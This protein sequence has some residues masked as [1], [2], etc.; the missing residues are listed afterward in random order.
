MK[1]I[2]SLFLTSLALC[3][4]A[5]ADEIK[6]RFLVGDEPNN[7]LVH[8]DQNNPANN[9][10]L[11]G[12]D[13][14][15]W[16]VRLI[17]NNQAIMPAANGY[18]I[19]DLNGGKLLKTVELE[20]VSGVW[21]VIPKRDG[22]KAVFYVK[23]GAKVAMID[24]NDKIVKTVKI[25]GATGS[26]LGRIDDNGNILHVG[27]FQF[28]ETTPDGEKVKSFLIPEGELRTRET[29]ISKSGQK[30]M[31]A[32]MAA[33]D[34]DGNYWFSNGYGGGVVKTDEN[35]KQLDVLGL[36]QHI[37]FASGFQILKNGNIVQGNWMGHKADSAKENSQL[38][39][40]NQKGDVVWSFHD[41]KAFACASALLI[42]DDLDTSK[43]AFEKDGV[44]Q[45]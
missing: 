27:N 15:C 2:T 31:N 6:H 7:A 36:K 42:L 23:G 11:K 41:P 12:F 24:A 35:G 29:P 1:K 32:F 34:A 38:F 33:K 25:P 10:T 21:S 19:I 44:L 5:N 45:N 9:W 16:D 4:L 3:T 26:G 22:G 30:Y 20:G 13:K 37:H 8:I 28:I 43:P 18:K 14:K 40:F 39:E 17:G